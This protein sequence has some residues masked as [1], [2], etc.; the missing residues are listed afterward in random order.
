MSGKLT[1]LLLLAVLLLAATSA[2]SINS[3][4][5]TVVKREDSRLISRHV[6]VSSSDDALYAGPRFHTNWCGTFLTVALVALIILA[7][8]LGFLKLYFLI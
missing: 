5:D 2:T 6:L 8:A 1:T 7:F 3:T 4:D